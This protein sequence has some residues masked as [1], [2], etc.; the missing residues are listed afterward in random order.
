MSLCCLEH[1]QNGQAPRSCATPRR[2]EVC[3]RQRLGGAESPA[4]V[5][6]AVRL[7]IQGCKKLVL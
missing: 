5:P 4:H 2:L 1:G 7:G 6:G 3:L